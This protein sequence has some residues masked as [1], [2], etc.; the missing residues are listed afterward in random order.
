MSI[1]VAR[2]RRILGKE[3]STL[4]DE[5]VEEVLACFYSLAE[6]FYSLKDYG[7]TKSDGSN[8]E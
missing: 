7:K 2:A 4:N 5:Q 6:A 3:A 8:Q 1:T